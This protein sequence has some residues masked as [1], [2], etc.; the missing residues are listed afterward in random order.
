MGEK[1]QIL[2]GV[3]NAW[4]HHVLDEAIIGIGSRTRHRRAA[5]QDLV[6]LGDNY[7]MRKNDLSHD[8]WQKF[9][10]EED[11]KKEAVKNLLFL[12]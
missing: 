8:T 9:T 1:D 12:F 11:T 5:R 6:E 4:N 2:G 10:I 7:S 3:P